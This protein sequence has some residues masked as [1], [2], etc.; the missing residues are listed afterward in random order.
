MMAKNLEAMINAKEVL[1]G[2]AFEEYVLPMI[3]E[4]L[5]MVEHEICDRDEKDQEN[6]G[7]RRGLLWILNRSNSLGREI[8]QMRKSAGQETREKVEE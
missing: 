1:D 8:E 6:R 4:K 2:S 5:A 3:L 7:F